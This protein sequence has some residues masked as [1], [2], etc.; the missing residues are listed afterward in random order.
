MI[1]KFEIWVLPH[2]LRAAYERAAEILRKTDFEDLYLN[3]RRDLNDLIE[4]L[5]LG[6]PYENFIEQIKL[7]I[8][9][10]PISYWENTI[11]PM[12]LFLRGIKLKKPNLR[13]ICYKNSAFDDFSIKVAEKVAMLTFRVCSSGR[14]DLGEWRKLICD[15]IDKS[16]AST[17]DEANYI[18]EIYK[19]AAGRRI[20]ICIS[21]FSGRFLLRKIRGAEINA[22]LR[23]IFI[24][25]HFTPLETLIRE[26]AE[27][28]RRGLTVNDER[29]IKMVKLHAE[30]IRE[31]I[32]MCVNF[33]EAYFKWLRDK[34]FKEYYA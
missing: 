21:D 2:D 27:K 14:V 7:K 23:Y 30:Y 4:D 12:L 28:L 26:A 13:I 8:P 15:I 19:K 25:Y 16:I 1:G 31:Y 22:R 11:K 33:D 3:I 17:E 10:E 9:C 20:S 18:F 29:I 24:P 34:R 6:A 32:L 5:A